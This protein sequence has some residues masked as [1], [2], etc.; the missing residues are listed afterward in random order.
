MVARTI[1]GTSRERQ[2]VSP[3][4]HLRYVGIDMATPVV[5]AIGWE[6]KNCFTGTINKVI[7]KVKYALTYHL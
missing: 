7:V 3:I 5:E 6:R 4:N 2:L 1:A